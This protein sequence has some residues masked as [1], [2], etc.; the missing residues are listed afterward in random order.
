MKFAGIIKS[1]VPC[2]AAGII[3]TAPVAAYAQENYGSTHTASGNAFG[4][5]SLS[6]NADI[7]IYGVEA[8]HIVS[9]SSSVSDIFISGYS[10]PGGNRDAGHFENKHCYNAT[11][12][13]IDYV[14]MAYN[15]TD[16]VCWASTTD[17]YVV[18]NGKKTSAT[19]LTVKGKS[20]SLTGC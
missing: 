7:T 8:H 20:I 5:C 17:S 15:S 18:V 1:L 2:L 12:C 11:S 9:C 16:D 3:A 14:F 4:P 10:I 6:V 13:S 19:P